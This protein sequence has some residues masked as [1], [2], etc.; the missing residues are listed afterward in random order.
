VALIRRRAE[1]PTE[2]KPAL[3]AG[4]LANERMFGRLKG[5]LTHHHQIRQIGAE[6]PRRRLRRLYRLLLVMR[7]EPS[8][9]LIGRIAWLSRRNV[10]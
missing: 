8:I 4:L 9:T 10:V 3:E 1:H 2:E 5:L 6:L 7:P